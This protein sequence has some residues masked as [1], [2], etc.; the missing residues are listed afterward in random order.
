VFQDVQMPPPLGIRTPVPVRWTGARQV[1]AQ[2]QNAGWAERRRAHEAQAA[3]VRRTE[4]FDA[5]VAE[6][7]RAGQI[8]L[9]TRPTTA[10]EE[11]QQLVYDAAER[12]GMLPSPWLRP[13]VATFLDAIPHRL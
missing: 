9:E 10:L 4:A 2:D 7:V 8:P 1:D 3:V 5:C 11:A 12:T 13:D 6:Q